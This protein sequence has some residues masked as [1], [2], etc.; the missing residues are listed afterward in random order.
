MKILLSVIGTLV[1]LFLIG[2]I[3]MYSG[4]VNVSALERPSGM[5]RWILS[6]TR[7]S[8]IESRIDEIQVPN[9]D[10]STMIN[11]GAE[12]YAHM[13]RGCHGA[14]GYEDTELAKSLEP[15]A[16]HLSM[17]RRADHFNAAESFWV[18][19]NGIMMTGMPAWGRTHSD[20]KIWDIVAF[21]KKLPQL[22]PEQYS[23]LTNAS[24]GES[25]EEHE[26]EESMETGHN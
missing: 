24:K 16:P 23:K 26:H 6:S 8:S 19:K 12:H 21:L 5:T 10:D 15:R 9:L 11:E 17:A 25:M 13:C 4:I 22:T 18:T 14:P 3:T 2:L 20:E 7:E 1:D